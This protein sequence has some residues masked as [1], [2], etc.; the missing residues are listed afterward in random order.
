[1]VHQFYNEI[2]TSSLKINTKPT[3]TTEV[4]FIYLF[5]YLFASTFTWACWLAERSVRK[6][7]HVCTVPHQEQ[8]YNLKEQP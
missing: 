5:I 6:Q 3:D 4:Y 1:M 8:N 2:Y 7:G